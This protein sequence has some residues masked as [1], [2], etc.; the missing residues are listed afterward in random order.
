M[1]RAVIRDISGAAAPPS[2]DLWEP[3]IITGEQIAAEAERLA[4]LARPA[5]GRREAMLIHPRAGAPGNGLTPGIRVV[6]SV[7]K[8]GERTAPIR[9]NSILLR[10]ARAAFIATSGRGKPECC[11]SRNGRRNANPG[12][13]PCAPL[14][15][16][17][18]PCASIMIATP[19][20]T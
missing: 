7:L 18:T 1:T 16:D 11:V 4:A 13:G 10:L 8:P 9:H 20:S 14:N 12:Q 3:V 5:N 2:L 15:E 17:Q 19:T 6:L